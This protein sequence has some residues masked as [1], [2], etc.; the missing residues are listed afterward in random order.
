MVLG[1]CK[2]LLGV[3]DVDGPERV[4]N[5]TGN[6]E[7]LVLLSK[8]IDFGDLVGRE[9]DVSEVLDDTGCGD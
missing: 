9:L 5:D 6:I 1:V 4:V 3:K 2:L 7:A 8:G